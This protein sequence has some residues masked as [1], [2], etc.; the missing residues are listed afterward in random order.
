MANHL[1][2]YILDP[3]LR[4]EHGLKSRLVAKTKLDVRRAPSNKNTPTLNFKTKINNVNE[5]SN[6]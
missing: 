5:I 1:Q 4:F 6:F 2:N 3:K